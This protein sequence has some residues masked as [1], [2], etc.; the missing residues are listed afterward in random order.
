MLAPAFAFTERWGSGKLWPREDRRVA[1]QRVGSTCSTSCTSRRRGVHYG[2]WEGR[3][4]NIPSRPLFTQPARIYH[5][6]DDAVVP[7]DR[8]S[9]DYAAHHGNVAAHGIRIRPTNCFRQ[10]PAGRP[11]PTPSFRS[12]LAEICRIRKRKERVGQFGAGV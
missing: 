6:V 11:P 10:C 2:M 8:V 12:L 5:G 7:I 4:R 1:R 9:R 3:S